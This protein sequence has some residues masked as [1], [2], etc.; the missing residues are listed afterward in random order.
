[1]LPVPSGLIRDNAFIAA[2]IVS[3]KIPRRS[4]LRRRRLDDGAVAERRKSPK[5]FRAQSVAN[6]NV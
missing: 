3:L 1:V 2:V 5:G 4:G 6:G